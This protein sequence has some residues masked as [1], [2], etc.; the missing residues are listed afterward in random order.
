M[1]SPLGMR[2]HFST[3][4]A[5]AASKRTFRG[6]RLASSGSESVSVAA[7][8]PVVALV[9]LFC[10]TSSWECLVVLRWGVYTAAPYSRTFLTLAIRADLMYVCEGPQEDAVMT[11]S[12]LI[13]LLALDLS[14]VTL[15]Q[16]EISFA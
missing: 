7:R 14:V 10:R 3:V 4:S 6:S 1:G 9:A 2:L 13:H 11:L 12:W 5:L 15:Q 8:H 16:S